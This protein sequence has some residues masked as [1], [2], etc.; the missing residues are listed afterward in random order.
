MKEVFAMRASG[1]IRVALA[2]GALLFA[3][4]AAAQYREPPEDPMRKLPEW[5]EPEAGEGPWKHQIHFATSEDGLEFTD[6]SAPLMKKASAPDIL[7]LKRDLAQVTGPGTKKGDLLIYTVDARGGEK[8]GTETISRLF[9]SDGGK[10]WSGARNIVVHWPGGLKHGT[11]L[12]PAVV[13]LDNGELRMFYYLAGTK[14]RDPDWGPQPGRPRPR[15]RN[16]VQPERGWPDGIADPLAHG[17][18]KHI[19]G[20]ATSADGINFTP[21][22]GQRI[23]AEEV[24]D[25]EVVRIEGEWLMFLSHGPEVLLAR[26]TDGMRYA[27]DENFKMSRGGNPGAVVLEGGKVRLYQSQEDGVSSVVFDPKTGKLRADQ[28]LRFDGAVSPAVFARSEGGFVAVF[29][30]AMNEK[31]P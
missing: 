24:T 13:Q 1:S 3:Q 14:V 18:E 25:P 31:K 16:S 15:P 12:D 11:I 7:E 2:A 26:S 20:S 19:I 23:E 8:P 28:G 22:D 6:A 29:R 4:H 21:D 9:S 30:R 10:T 17:P 27:M 5:R